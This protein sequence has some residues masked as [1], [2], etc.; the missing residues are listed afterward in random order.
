M[1]SSRQLANSNL[2][3]V[4]LGGGSRCA[5]SLARTCVKRKRCVD[6]CTLGNDS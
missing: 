3:A 5:L 1:D 2:A 6:P 4:R